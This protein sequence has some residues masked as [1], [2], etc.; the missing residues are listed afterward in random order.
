MQMRP[1]PF[2]EE[3]TPALLSLQNVSVRLHR[4]L[5]IRA[6]L[7]NSVKLFPGAVKV[8]GEAQQLEKECAPTRIGRV[9]F[10]LFRNL[11][12]CSRKLTGSQESF[13]IRLGEPRY[14]QDV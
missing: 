7:A 6:L 11:P 13:S 2:R 8:A 4:Q 1:Q 5:G 14:A 3:S 12:N 10:N 9:G